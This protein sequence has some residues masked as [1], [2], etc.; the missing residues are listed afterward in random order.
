MASSDGR[1][2]RARREGMH[3]CESG[4]PGSPAVV[5]LHA[6]GTSGRMWAAHMAGVAG[7]HSL[8]PDLPGFGHSNRLPWRS[9]I[10]TADQIAALIEQRTPSRRA[11]VVG[12]SLGGAIAHTFWSAAPTL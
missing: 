3:V 4:R 7:D 6:V 12:L 5:F 11:H 1:A 2:V 10:D 9:R 8:A